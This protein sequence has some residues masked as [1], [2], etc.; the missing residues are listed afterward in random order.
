MEKFIINYERLVKKWG[1]LFI[2]LPICLMAAIETLNGFGRKVLVPFPCGI[3]AVESLLVIVV[4]FGVPL[5]A[6]ERGH[7]E[8]DILARKLPRSI[9]KHL[10]LFSDL[11]GIGAF[12]LLTY[13]AWMEAFR[14][15]GIMEVRVGI[16]R[17]PVWIFKALFCIGMSFFTIQLVLNLIKSIHRSSGNT[18]YGKTGK[19]QFL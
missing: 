13:G 18:A 19:A 10:S 14:S 15:V 9:Q 8:V 17:F 5:V 1:V 12:G 16:Y 4:Y 3:E 11:I 7:V 6:M 2:G